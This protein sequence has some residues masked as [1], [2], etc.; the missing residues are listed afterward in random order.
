M[1][2]F[3]EIA[4]FIL[5]I[6]GVLYGVG[7]GLLK[8]WN[9]VVANRR[10]HRL[11]READDRLHRKQLAEDYAESIKALNELGGATM[12]FHDYTV[13]GKVIDKQLK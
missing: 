4:I 2:G 8:A 6:L 5:I 13:K 3:G 10:N 12:S 11:E 1:L 7:I 9:Y